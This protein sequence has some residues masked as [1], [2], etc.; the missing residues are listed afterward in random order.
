MKGESRTQD[1]ESME[2]SLK[3]SLK[4]NVLKLMLEC[5]AIHKAVKE[6]ITSVKTL[7]AGS[8]NHDQLR[9]NTVPALSCISLNPLRLITSKDVHQNGFRNGVITSY[10]LYLYDIKLY[11]WREQNIPLMKHLKVIFI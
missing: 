11:A 10:L 8:R 1:Q 6:L 7:E 2:R 5:L 9:S 3:T 4:L